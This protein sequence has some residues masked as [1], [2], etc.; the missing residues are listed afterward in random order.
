MV[1]NHDFVAFALLHGNVAFA[2]SCKFFRTVPRRDIPARVYSIHCSHR[3]D[4]GDSPVGVSQS[5]C[6]KMTDNLSIARI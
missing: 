5:R 2:L 3:V 4:S 6:D 1:P